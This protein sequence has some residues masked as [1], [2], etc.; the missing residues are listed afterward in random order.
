MVLVVVLAFLFNTAILALVTRRL[1]GVPVGWPRTIAVSAVVALVG[2]TLL[3]SIG[4]SIGVISPDGSYVP[5][6]DPMLVGGVLVLMLAWSVAVGAAV[7]VVIEVIVPTGTFPEPVAALRGIPASVRRRRRWL[8]IMRIATTHGLTGWWGLGAHREVGDAHRVARA[9]RL[10]LSDAGVTF[11]K[12]GQMLS[13]RADLI[14]EEF[15]RELS[16]LTSDVAPE[17]WERIEAV[18]TA[19]LGR[20]L[21]EVF[22]DLDRRP[23]AAASVGQVHAGTLRSGQA[24]VVKVQRPGALAQVTADLDILRR[25]A[26]RLERRTA[27]GRRLRVRD[28]VDGFAT[29]LDEELDYR[30]EAS[31]VR[32]VSAG[33]GDR[34]VVH[35]PWVEES[36]SG[37]TVLVMERIDGVPMSRAGSQI[38]RLDAAQRSRLA[39]G[40]LGVVLRQILA[41]GVFH[42][43]LH[44]GNVLL[45]RDGR[46]A[47]LDF[48]SVGRL[49]RPAREAL[50]RLLLAVRHDDAIA[51]TDA[52]LTLLDRPAQLDDR[53]L[54]RDLGSLIVRMRHGG[55]TTGLFGDLLTLVVRHGFTVPGQVAAVFR[56]VG[57]LE[58]T[59][60]Q[61]DPHLDFVA[62]AEQEGSSV[63]AEQLRPDAVRTSIESRLLQSW[64]LLERLPRRLDAVGRRLEDGE[65]SVRVR[66]LDDPSDRRFVTGLVREVTMAVIAAACA[67]IATIFLVSEGGPQVGPGLTLYPLLGSIFLLFACVLAVRVLALALSLSSDRR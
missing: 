58:G 51:A 39:H 14:G 11:V 21:E 65:L 23:L 2:N 40:L 41:T 17:P 27:W 20:P 45:Q 7:L 44:G 42:A 38:A 53:L 9:L 19:H 32:A 25:L 29:S 3:T 64:P 47:L 43:D 16:H 24:V 31:N 46:A 54:E 26:D 50:A 56:A 48:G 18:L 62:T 66:V 61:I 6:L 36:L 57:A 28:L 35:V 30:V 33:L 59:L 34:G 1:V 55:N 4:T 60:A 8:D 12:F 15:A 67:L 13:T 52:L 10:A 37:R 49:D 63:F 22:T 5:T